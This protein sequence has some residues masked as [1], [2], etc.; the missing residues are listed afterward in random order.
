MVHEGKIFP[1]VQTIV[2]G[3]LSTITAVGIPNVDLRMHA[4]GMLMAPTMVLLL[5]WIPLKAPLDKHNDELHFSHQAT[6]VWMIDSSV[7][8]RICLSSKNQF[9]I[10]LCKPMKLLKTLITYC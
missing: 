4:E 6:H 3:Q 1:A 5:I 9:F 7:K 10:L 2:E 8:L